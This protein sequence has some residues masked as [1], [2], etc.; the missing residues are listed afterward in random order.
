[1]ATEIERHSYLYEKGT[2][3]SN[4]NYVITRILNRTADEAEYGGSLELLLEL[5][6]KVQFENTL[7][8]KFRYKYSSEDAIVQHSR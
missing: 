7:M 3:S 1:M 2:L 8:Q 5:S 6:R 4:D